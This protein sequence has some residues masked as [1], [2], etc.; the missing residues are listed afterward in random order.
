MNARLALAAGLALLVF[1]LGLAGWLLYY[2]F[3]PGPP[4]RE[5]SAVVTIPKGASLATIGIVLAEAKLIDE[6]ARFVV[7][8]KL[9]GLGGKLKAGEF[10]LATGMPPYQLLKALAAAKAIQYTITIPEGLRASEIGDVFGDGGWF[11]PRSFANLLV[12]RDFIEKQGL[13]GVSSLEGYLYPDTY[14][15]TRDNRGAERILAMM[16][17]RFHQVWND[18][19]GDM[20][21]KPHQEKTVILASMVEK[22]TGAAVE[23]PLIAGVFLNRLQLGMRLQ[24]DP[25][26]VYG[27]ENFSGKITRRHLQTETPYNTYTID[28]LPAGPICSPGR[29]ALLAV[30]KPTPTK[31][32]YFVSKNDGTHHFSETLAEHNSAVQRYQRKNSG[33][34]GK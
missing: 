14:R 16:V 29:D 22:E 20:E 27:I 3:R 26:V 1:I 12:D 10:R 31:D 4:S 15:L 23:R 33:E 34:K 11:D 19:V 5:A 9:S 7:L 21:Q 17:G 32:L 24:S 30:L 2:G 6:D 13:A 8:A 18:L 28:G 25:T